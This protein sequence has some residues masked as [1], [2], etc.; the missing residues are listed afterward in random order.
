[1]PEKRDCQHPITRLE[2]LEGRGYGDDLVRCLACGTDHLL[3]QHVIRVDEPGFG[4]RVM[5]WTQARAGSPACPVAT[6][7]E[8]M[9]LGRQEFPKA[10]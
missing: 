10:A 1:M 4:R 9:Q 2:L 6:L 5:A 7:A 8:L 3:R